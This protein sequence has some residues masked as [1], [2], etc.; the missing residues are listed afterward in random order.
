MNA[1]HTP[2]NTRARARTLLAAV[3]AAG[4]IAIGAAITLNAPTAHAIPESTIKSEC[5]DANG[6]TYSSAKDGGDTWSSCV[7]HDDE[8]NTYIDTYKNGA[9]MG[10]IGP[11]VKGTTKPVRPPHAPPLLPGT[12]SHPVAPGAAP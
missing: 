1:V 11:D 8:G 9:Y 7:Y 10:T 3:M 4:A 2:D 12:T 6:G 5:A